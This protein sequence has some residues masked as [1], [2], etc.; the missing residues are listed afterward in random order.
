MTS[1]YEEHVKMFAPLG[2]VPGITPEQVTATQARGG[3][4]KAG[5]P[6]LKHFMKLGSWFA[7]TPADL[8]EH[9]KK[10]VARFPG[11]EHIDLST[12]ISTPQQVMLE[13]IHWVARR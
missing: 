3:W 7:G 4:T 2:F 13:Q 9:L 12:S 11:L 5:V 10:F 8:V 1:F 6:T